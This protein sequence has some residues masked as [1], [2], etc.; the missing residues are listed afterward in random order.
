MPEPGWRGI[1]TKFAHL[2]SF[3][4]LSRVYI[5]CLFAGHIKAFSIL[6][7]NKNSYAAQPT[8]RPA[9]CLSAKSPS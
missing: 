3:M 9:E 8:E 1:I 2:Q 4:A 5:H 6:M 7:A